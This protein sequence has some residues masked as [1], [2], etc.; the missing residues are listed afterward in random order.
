MVVEEAWVG[1]FVVRQTGKMGIAA[2]REVAV[3]V[4]NGMVNW[5]GPRDVACSLWLLS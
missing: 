2:G 1:G 3:E 5:S 4:V